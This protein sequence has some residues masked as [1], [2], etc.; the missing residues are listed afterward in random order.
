[1][2]QLVIFLAVALGSLGSSVNGDAP[3]ALARRG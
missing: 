1:M 3:P 2:M